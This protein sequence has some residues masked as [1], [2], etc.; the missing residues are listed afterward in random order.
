[1]VAVGFLRFPE[2]N[3]L[4][5]Q[6]C[7]LDATSKLWL[8]LA[9]ALTITISERNKALIRLLKTLVVHTW[10]FVFDHNVSPLRHIPDVGI[11]HYILQVLGLMWAVSFS[12][13]IGS[14]TFLAYSILGHAVLIAAA[15][16]TVATFTVAAKRPKLF[17]RGAGRRSDGE[18]N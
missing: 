12:V 18:H 7:T 5:K 14:Y 13:A 10:N 6:G 8:T 16:I 1:V 4:G 15:A 2:F 3:W 9:K 11:R 17:M